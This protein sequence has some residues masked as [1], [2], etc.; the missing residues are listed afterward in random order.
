[1]S[2][3]IASRSPLVRVR[4][5]QA[6]HE[7]HENTS[8]EQAS[9]LQP[10]ERSYIVARLQADQG[11]NAA[12]RKVRFSDVVHV[13]KDYKVWLGGFMYFGL[14]VP[15]YGYAFFSPAI[16]GTYGYGP[17]QTQ[18]HS[19]PPWAAA[20]GLA[21]LTAVASDWV[22][23]RFLFAAACACVSLAG[24]VILLSVHHNTPLEYAALFLIAMGTY[25]AMPIIV[26]W[27]NMNMGGH[28]RRSVGFTRIPFFFCSTFFFPVSL[29]LQ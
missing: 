19:V 10:D 3:Q 12:E 22:R 11:R 25:S 7:P 24:F 17:I 28:H 14:I 20:F 5:V 21:M 2:S 8:P 26:C 15:A 6:N 4:A 18:L 1:V 23:H 27:F 13:M 29:P 16:L 9:W